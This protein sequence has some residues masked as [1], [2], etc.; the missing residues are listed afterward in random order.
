[1]CKYDIFEVFPDGSSRRRARISGRYNKE[2]TLQEFAE[3]SE[4]QF[5]AVE[6]EVGETLP[7]NLLD[8]RAPQRTARPTT[9]NLKKTG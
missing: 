8:P 2:R 6:I 4:N 9:D 7:L 5:Y 1:M 3:I